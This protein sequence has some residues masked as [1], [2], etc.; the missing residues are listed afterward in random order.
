MVQ[1]RVSVVLATINRVDELRD[2]LTHMY[3]QKGVD[4]ELVV[5]DNGSTDGTREMMMNEFPQAIYQWLPYN[6][7]THAINIGL[8]K[9]TG[10][11]IWFSNNDSYPEEETAFADLIAL[12]RK[13]QHMHVV[14]TADVEVNDNY[15]VYNWHPIPLPKDIPE[16]GVPTCSFH[17]TGAMVRREVY[18]QIGGFWDTFLYEEMDFCARAIQ[19]GFEVR[20]VPHIRTLH[21]ASHKARSPI[22]RWL[23][24]SRNKMRFYWR[25]FPWFSAVV[26]SVAFATYFL[27]Q[28]IPYRATPLQVLDCATGMFATGV[29]AWRTERNVL[30]KD[31][32]KRVTLGEGPLD[33]ILR[34][35][36][37]VVRRKIDKRKRRKQA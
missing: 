27:L 19:A 32:L 37:H 36:R 3:A 11:F 35:I 10:E 30:T 18:T 12:F 15:R 24:A 1:N 34:D 13:Y 23:M 14:G 17:G 29:R 28:A 9:S 2:A 5:I 16:N 26:R 20:Y 6:M 4:V 33:P 31:Q 25:Y 8:E 7:G 21:F 22:G